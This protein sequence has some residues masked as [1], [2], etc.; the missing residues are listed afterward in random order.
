MREGKTVF[1]GTRGLG[2]VRGGEAPES[3]G[4]DSSRGRIPGDDFLESRSLHYSS[5]QLP[6]LFT[7]I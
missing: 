7:L 6:A 1:E 2:V 5:P 3:T 4:E